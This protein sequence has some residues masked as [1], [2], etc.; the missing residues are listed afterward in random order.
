M[1]SNSILNLIVEINKLKQNETKQKHHAVLGS[2]ENLFSILYGYSK[3]AIFRHMLYEV[4]SE[5][6]NM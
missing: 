3:N 1:N 6:E 2:L 5:I 4:F